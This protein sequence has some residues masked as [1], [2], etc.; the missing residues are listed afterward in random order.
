MGTLPSLAAG[1][2]GGGL[3]GEVGGRLTKSF[4]CV[5]T[6]EQRGNKIFAPPAK[7][8]GERVGLPLWALPHAFRLLSSD[9]GGA[10]SRPN[11]EALRDGHHAWRGSFSEDL[12]FKSADH[13]KRMKEA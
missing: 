7:G 2:R 6:S 1:G 12:N 13:V 4:P 8:G 11:A 9:A 3:R 10:P 5:I